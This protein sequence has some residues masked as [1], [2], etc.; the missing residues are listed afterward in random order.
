MQRQNELQRSTNEVVFWSSIYSYPTG[1]LLS[2]LSLGDGLVLV[3]RFL[4]KVC[5]KQEHSRDVLSTRLVDLE[6]HHPTQTHP[7]CFCNPTIVK[8]FF[9]DHCRS[10]LFL[11]P[12]Y[13]KT[14][15][16]QR[17]LNE[18]FSEDLDT[19]LC[20]RRSEYCGSKIDSDIHDLLFRATSLL[21][22]QRH[23]V[24]SG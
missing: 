20:H 4:R 8:S 13:Q 12:S 18:I 14:Q 16:P 5:I 24:T 11:C 7:K 22:L 10:P 3:P 2:S 19:S 17:A 15:I 6:D 23:D 1:K 21:R 9:L